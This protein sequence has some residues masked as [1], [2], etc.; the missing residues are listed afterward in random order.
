MTVTGASERRLAVALAGMAQATLASGALAA[1]GLLA[2][3][4]SA[5]MVGVVAVVVAA[6]FVSAWVLRVWWALAVYMHHQRDVSVFAAENWRSQRRILAHAAR[7]FLRPRE[8]QASWV[9]HA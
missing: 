7:L 1:V 9:R 3:L 2:A 5:V 4:L 8:V 6:L